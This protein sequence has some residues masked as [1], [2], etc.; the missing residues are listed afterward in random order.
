MKVSL[1]IAKRYLIS[2][3][4]RNIINIISTIS[5]IGVAIGTMALVV[6]LSVHNGFDGLMKSLLNTFDPDLK[7]TATM[8]KSFQPDSITNL[9]N[10]T[11]GV[12][13]YSEVVEEKALLKYREKQNIAI[14]KGV[15]TNYVNITGIDTMIVSGDFILF[16]NNQPFM[17]MGELLSYFLGFQVNYVKPV[18]IHAARR[19]KKVSLNPEQAIRTEIIHPVGIFK[20]HPEIDNEYALVPISF[21]RDLFDY[22]SK[23]TAIEI[24]L[25]DNADTEKIEALIQDKLG[26]TFKVLNKYEQ[27]EFEYKTIETEKWAIFLILSFILLIAS[28]NIVGSLTMLIIDKKRDI[29]ILRSMG[30]SMPTIRNIFLFEG[31]LI[32]IIGAILGLIFGFLIAYVQKTFELVKLQGSGTFIIDAY[33]VEIHLSDFITILI[34]VLLIGFLAAWYPIRYITKRHIIVNQ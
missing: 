29:A 11:E 21:A 33:P 32:S 1:F 5:I 24:K 15:D 13:H 30:A 12:L 9:L 28:F 4:S 17:V 14:I 10:E 27:H 26:K 25:K 18:S 22:Q 20:I 6:I 31:W 7:I 8:G 23:V 3:K 2:K 34:T 16:Q 19:T